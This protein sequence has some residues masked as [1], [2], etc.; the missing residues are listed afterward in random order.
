LMTYAM[1]LLYGVA[2]E[3]HY[4]CRNTP[5]QDLDPDAPC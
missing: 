2:L 3:G 1:A 5:R 4:E